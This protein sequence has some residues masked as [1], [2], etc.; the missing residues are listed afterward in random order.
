MIKALDVPPFDGEIVLA[1]N[2][3]VERALLYDGKLRVSL[4]PKDKV[5]D[6]HIEAR[7]W[8]PPA[9]PAIVFDDLAVA[10]R[11]EAQQVSLNRIEGRI[12]R[13]EVKG[14]AKASWASGIQAEGDFSLTNGELAALMSMFTRDFTASGSV[15]V[16]ATYA[17]R[18]TTLENLFAEPRV[19]ANFNIERGELNNV[20]IV[21]AVQASSRD[22]TRG[23][24]TRFNNLSGSLQ[25]S[26]KSYSF[27]QLRLGSGQMNATG[28]V[29]VAPNGDLSGRIS[30]EVGTKTVVVARGN[31]A[32]GGN[33]KSP[34]L[35]P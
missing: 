35:R 22:G 32:V 21:R 10:A 11:F 24:R 27:R 13:G 9:G 4:T 31:L 33:M 29:N 14:A 20:D 23:G 16:N 30:A 2:G 17:L 5:L 3:A 19:E 1:G 7:S 34:V 25:V 26:G 8:Q 6:A 15:N 18:G 28:N 12:G